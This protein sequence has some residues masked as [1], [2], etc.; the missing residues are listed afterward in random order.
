[1]SVNNVKPTGYL[2]EPS[3]M[4]ITEEHRKTIFTGENTED[5]VL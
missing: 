4:K 2:M 1:M 5:E 3:D